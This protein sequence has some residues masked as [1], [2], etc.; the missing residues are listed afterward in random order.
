MF[1]WKS[2]KTMLNILGRGFSVIISYKGANTLEA[3]YKQHIGIKQSLFSFCTCFEAGAILPSVFNYSRIS[4]SSTLN[5]R[6]LCIHNAIRK[7]HGTMVLHLYNCT[8]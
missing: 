8:F 6:T 4:L 2:S 3:D 1:H 7:D 5:S